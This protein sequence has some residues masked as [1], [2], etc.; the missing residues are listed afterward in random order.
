VQPM[1]VHSI[2][3]LAVVCTDIEGVPGG[4]QAQIYG[5]AT[6]DGAGS[7]AY[8]I[9]VED[10]GE[11]G[12]SDKY[13][14]M[15]SNGYDSGKP[16]AHRWQHPDSLNVF[17]SQRLWRKLAGRALTR[18]ARRSYSLAPPETIGT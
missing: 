16:D 6:I 5:E 8:R 18:R 10:R 7:H 1:N 4:K 9:H 12:T 15:L 11:P 13:W 14:I 3:V 2:N 17:P